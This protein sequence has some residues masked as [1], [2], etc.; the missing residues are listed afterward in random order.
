MARNRFFYFIEKFPVVFC[1]EFPQ[2]VRFNNGLLLP[3]NLDVQIKK[4]QR[5]PN[6][7]FTVYFI[8]RYQ[9]TVSLFKYKAIL[10]NYSTLHYYL[11]KCFHSINIKCL[12]IFGFVQ[13]SLSSVET[14]TS[15]STGQWP[16]CHQKTG[17]GCSSSRSLPR[18]RNLHQQPRA[19]SSRISYPWLP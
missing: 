11:K 10:Y 5:F 12:R 7:N 4:R 14:F 15:I 1:Q 18:S 3:E 13:S 9:F 2:T 19:N 8:S 6:T 16:N 17:R